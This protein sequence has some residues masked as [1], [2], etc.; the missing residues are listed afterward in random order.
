MADTDF[1]IKSVNRELAML[2]ERPQFV[3]DRFEDQDAQEIVANETIELCG[4]GSMTVS[5]DASSAVTPGTVTSDNIDLVIN[6]H[7]GVFLDIPRLDRLKNLGGGN[8]W[9]AGVAR[10][11]TNALRNDMDETYLKDATTSASWSSAATPTYTANPLGDSL[12]R[13]DFVSAIAMLS[14]QDGAGAESDMLWVLDPWAMAAVRS[15]ADWQPNGTM[16]ERGFVGIPTLGTLFGIPLVA[17]RS[18]TRNHAVACTAVT[19]SGGT[20]VA[21][22]GVGHGIVC[23][24]KISTTLL[25]TNDTDVI[26]SAVGTTSIS[27]PS[28]G[29]GA[30]ADGVGLITSQASRSM[31]LDTTHCH[32]GIQ[33]MPDIR[34]KPKTGTSTEEL[35][36]TSVYGF[37]SRAGRAISLYGPVG[38]V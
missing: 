5:S 19:E 15:I 3:L 29:S 13:G 11:A 24:E 2:N 21:T 38:S 6:R 22:V 9:A 33:V 8:R 20:A 36:V 28:T 14:D 27:Y 1:R 16:A 34:I 35:E 26:V 4:L 17:T 32:T 10:G 30:F 31:L 7:P 37:V 18:V 12:A 25:T 23:G